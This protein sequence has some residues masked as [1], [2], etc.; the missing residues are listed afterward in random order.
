MLNQRKP[1][2]WKC[3]LVEVGTL[4]PTAH[5]L[6]KATLAL[7]NQL[8][9]EGKRVLL[10]TTAQDAA[11]TLEDIFRRQ[12]IETL[13]ID[14]KTSS[15]PWARQLMATP[16]DFL[17]DSKAQLVIASPAIESGLSI[18]GE[19]LFDAIVLYASGLEPSTAYEMLGRYRIAEVP[20]YLC[21]AESA[22]GG[23]GDL[24]PGAILTQWRTEISAAL[25]QH[26]IEPEYQE[27]I[28][29]AHA[30]AADYLARQAAGRIVLRQGIPDHL[31]D[32]DH[33]VTPY[34][35]DL[36]G[37]E[38]DDLKEGKRRIR[39]QR[40]ADWREAE[41][42]RYTPEQARIR[43]RDSD[44]TWPE[45]VACIKCL[46]RDRYGD[47]VDQDS[48]IDAYWADDKVGKLLENAVRT[49][50]EFTHRGMAEESD[51]RALM[52]QV[53][54][55]GTIWGADFQ[56]RAQVIDLLARLQLHLLIE[57][58]ERGELIHKDHWAVGVIFRKAVDLR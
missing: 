50:T 38:G 4:T 41:D 46:A 43:I 14:S 34:P 18:E 24:D 22:S 26:Q 6:K 12:G 2:K 35:L 56:G 9:S 45:Q 20:H 25:T 31:S 47:L 11:E 40:C 15:E 42:G 21:L 54:A 39:E 17:R 52:R 13:R 27:A 8:L 48:W 29:I 16:G 44:L 10:L 57:I 37:N 5:T 32:D 58:A 30:L 51:R 36:S 19:G 1:P 3:F 28:A 7:C 23:A 33:T 53:K 49:V 55:T